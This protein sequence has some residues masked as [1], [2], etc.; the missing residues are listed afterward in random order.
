MKLVLMRH[1]LPDYDLSQ[2]VAGLNL[3][4]AYA[5]YKNAGLAAGNVIPEKSL[6]VAT[7]C[8][9]RVTSELFRATESLRLMNLPADYSDVL[10]N[11]SEPPHVNV[12]FPALPLMLW[13][14]VFRGASILGFSPNGEAQADLKLREQAA[15]LQLQRWSEE[16]GSVLLLGHGF[17]NYLLGKALRRDGW[18]CVEETGYRHWS[19]RTYRL[20]GEFS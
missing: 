14:T 10:F 12:P 20:I 2:R 3:S 1:G 11:E 16:Y 19:Y 17:M 13:A 9:W 15:S 6:A 5:A 18:V 7:E 8:Q 4:R